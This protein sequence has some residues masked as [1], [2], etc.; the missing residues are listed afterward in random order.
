MENIKKYYYLYKITNKINNKYY[1][2]VHGTN[3]LND[4]YFGSGRNL[5]LAIKKYGKENFNKEIIKFCNSYKE[6]MIE[7][8]LLVN[9]KTL[10]DRNIYNSEIGGAGGKVWTKELKK[11]VSNS[12]KGKIPWIKGKKHTK[13]TREKMKKNHADVS[14]KNNPMYGIDVSTLMTKE[15]NRE[16]IKKISKANKNKQRT[17]EHKKK[18]SE[19]AKKR[20]WIVHKSGKISHCISK[21][22]KRLKSNDWQLGKKYK[23]DF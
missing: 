3:N 12:N 7:E 9:N 20:F 23:G 8:R 2:G 17:D 10:K 18:Y 22:D 15:A 19:Y 13:E 6:L 4:G 5:K 11:K 14:G 16:R 21:N 1:I